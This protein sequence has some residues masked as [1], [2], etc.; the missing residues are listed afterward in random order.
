M[1]LLFDTNLLWLE[2]EM[3]I[4]PCSSYSLLLVSSLINDTED[5]VEIVFH[6]GEVIHVLS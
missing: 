1:S 6:F 2:L 3:L 5:T 4:V